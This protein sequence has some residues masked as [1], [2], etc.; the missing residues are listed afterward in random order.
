[1]AKD[2]IGEAAVRGVW[3]VQQWQSKGVRS[4]AR[5]RCYQQLQKLGWSSIGAIA[6]ALALQQQ[7]QG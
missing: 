7:E 4:T 6:C 1:M 5:E 3:E 2:G